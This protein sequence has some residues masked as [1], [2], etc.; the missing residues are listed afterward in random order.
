MQKNIMY[1]CVQFL[2]SFAIITWFAKL[3]VDCIASAVDS[4]NMTASSSTS[5][6]RFDIVSLLCPG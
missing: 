2:N 1:S 4:T 6:S 3:L 5:W